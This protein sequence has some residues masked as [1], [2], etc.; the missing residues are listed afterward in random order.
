MATA[1]RHLQLYSYEALVGNIQ[2]TTGITVSQ[3]E[4]SQPTAGLVEVLY[5]KFIQIIFALDFEE[6]VSDL[7]QQCDP[8]SLCL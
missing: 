8:V 1:L 3:R 7:Y 2:R 4:L 6:Y 5:M